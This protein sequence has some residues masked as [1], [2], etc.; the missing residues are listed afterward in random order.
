MV[1]NSIME[2]EK[3]IKKS[4]KEIQALEAQKTGLLKFKAEL[5][6]E[7]NELSEN[8]ENLKAYIVKKVASAQAAL[9]QKNAA[10]DE[11]LQVASEAE[12]RAKDAEG[13]IQEMHKEMK[14][15]LADAK[16][17]SEG[18]DSSRT[19]L[20]VTKTVLTELVKHIETELG[21]L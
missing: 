12:A 15:D 7:V 16:K 1:N 4:K 21:K 14:K 8:K 19:D 18:N 5:Q 3:I 20:K 13:A 17:I 9:D 11:K 6:A 10:L 2:I